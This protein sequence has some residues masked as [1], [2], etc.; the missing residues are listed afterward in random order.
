M[1]YAITGVRKN[2]C[3]DVCDAETG[4]PSVNDL[5]KYYQ[6]KFF[7]QIC[8]ERFEYRDDPL[9]LVIN[10]IKSSTHGDRKATYKLY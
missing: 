7:Y 6:H 10:T 1:T 8:Q 9:V 2:T 3:N 5:V 4:F